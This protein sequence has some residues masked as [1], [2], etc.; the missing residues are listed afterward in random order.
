MAGLIINLFEYVTYGVVLAA[1][2]DAAMKPLAP[3]AVAIVLVAGEDSPA[4][5]SD[6]GDVET[7]SALST[8]SRFSFVCEQGGECSPRAQRGPQP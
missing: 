3:V 7:T 6:A 4:G 2:W 8:D 1:N 5:D